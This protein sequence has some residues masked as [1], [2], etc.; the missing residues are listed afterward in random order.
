DATQLEMAV[1]NLA[2]NARDAMPEGGDLVIRTVPRQIAADTDLAP[3]EYVELSVTDTGIGMPPE[4][5]ARAFDPFFTTKGIGKGT[6]LGLSQVYGLAR[7][8]GGAARIESRPGA[9]TT[10]RLF[11]RRTTATGEM[12]GSS[13]AGGVA[14]GRTMTTVLVVDDDPDMRRMLADMLDV[15]GYRVRAADSAAFGL[16]ALAEEPADLLVVDFAMPGMN[17]AEMARIVRDR[18]PALP[19]V[20]A[21]GYADTAAIEGAIGPEAKLLRKPFR[22]DE[23]HAILADALGRPGEVASA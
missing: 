17:G 10:V 19:I 9:G 16:A 21:S 5:V 6:G 23:L 12:S 3:G 15:L 11:L 20:F 8:A 7:Q 1:L 2:I 22:L 13:G 14:Q 4:V 18:L